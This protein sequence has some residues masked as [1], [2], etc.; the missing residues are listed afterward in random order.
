M[1]VLLDSKDLAKIDQEFAVESV[2]WQPL[3]GGAKSI[4]ASDFVGANEVRVNKM[5][6]FIDAEY[7]RNGENARTKINVSKETRKLEFERWM[8]YD[9]DTL[10][11]SENGSYNVLNVHNEHVRLVAIPNKDRVAIH[12]LVENSEKL[13]EETIT[14]ANALAAYDDAEQYM[15]D[16]EVS[17]PFV[18]FASS[19]FVKKLKQADGVSKQFTTNT[20]QLNGIDRRVNT[21]DND[22]PIITVPPARLQ[23]NIDGTDRDQPINFILVPLAVAAPIEKYNT[24]DLVPA[25]SDRDGYR[26]TIKGLDYYD[27]IVFD[28]AKKAIYVNHQPSSTEEP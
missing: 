10:D 12:R 15:K 2:V 28:N 5:S 1:A 13:V 19:E 23:K 6:G 3:M 25:S 27:L 4:A 11:E 20:V 14:S 9:L 22:I 18:M 8:G 26:D 24:V 16:A 7:V 17:G 21:L